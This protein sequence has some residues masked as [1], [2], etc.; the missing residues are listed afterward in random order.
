M[1]QSIKPRF[2]SFWSSEIKGSFTYLNILAIR[3]HVDQQM[4]HKHKPN[5]LGYRY[6]SSAY[7]NSHL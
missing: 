2:I 7:H 4:K 1:W 6:G 3:G 5:S